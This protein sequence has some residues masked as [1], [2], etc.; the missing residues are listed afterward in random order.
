[1]TFKECLTNKL[2]ISLEAPEWSSAMKQAMVGYNDLEN[3][4]CLDGFKCEITQNGIAGSSMMSKRECAVICT[5][6]G[7]FFLCPAIGNLP[8]AC[9]IKP[10]DIRVVS[11]EKSL[12]KATVNIKTNDY[13]M[14]ITVPRKEGSPLEKTIDKVYQISL[15]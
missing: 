10:R 6:K 12:L 9:L 5:T 15:R 7:I 14:K 2:K 3:L 4:E 1:M 13:V 8:Y 11:S